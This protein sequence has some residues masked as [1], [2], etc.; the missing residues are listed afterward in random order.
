[1][2]T[3]LNIISYIL[4]ALAITFFV[5]GLRQRKN[6]RTENTQQD[7]AIKLKENEFNEFRLLTAGVTQYLLGGR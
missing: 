1:M 4:L 2:E 5:V 3:S 6:T 7:E